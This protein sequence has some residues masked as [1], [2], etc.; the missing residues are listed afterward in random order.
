MCYALNKQKSWSDFCFSLDVNLAYRKTRVRW[1]RGVWWHNTE[2][3]ALVSWFCRYRRHS[4]KGRAP[5]DW[6]PSYRLTV[7]SHDRPEREGAGGEKAAVLFCPSVPLR[8]SWQ[9]HLGYGRRQ[10]GLL[11]LQGRKSSEAAACWVTTSPSNSADR[12]WWQWV[13]PFTCWWRPAGCWLRA[14]P[15]A[16]PQTLFPLC[17]DAE[18]LGSWAWN[19]AAAYRRIRA[20]PHGWVGTRSAARDHSG[21]F[22]LTACICTQPASPNLISQTHF[23]L[24]QVYEKADNRVLCLPATRSG[25][26]KWE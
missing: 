16:G 13:E 4:S 1:G 11:F 15:L 14:E 8:T 9:Q 7:S 17:W 19:N 20:L 3:T 25:S 22:P 26:G 10:P 6:F 5:R 2:A 23:K 12:S 24:L 18:G 21:P